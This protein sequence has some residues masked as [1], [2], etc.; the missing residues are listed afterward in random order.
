[1]LKI[2]DK[3]RFRRQFDSWITDY[4][5]SLF[6]HAVWMTGN[7]DT[8]ADMV[9][10]AFF[11]AWRSVGKLKDESR[12]FPWLLTILQRCIYREQRQMYRDR[13]TVQW[14]SEQEQPEVGDSFQLL[15]IYS[16]LETLSMKHREVFV[17]HYLHG[18]SYEE[19]SELLDTPKGTVMSRLSRAR[20]ALQ[21]LEEVDS[22]DVVIQLDR[23]R[24]EQ[25]GNG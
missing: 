1:M 7:R 6:R 9:Q 20:D 14:L 13:D 22:R 21:K 15:S 11:Q 23:K 5:E 17:L 3:S 8:A 18:F 10:E 25:D 2:L 24:L 16:A 19:I 12:A 4:H